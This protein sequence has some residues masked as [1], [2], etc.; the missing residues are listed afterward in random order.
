MTDEEVRLQS[1]KLEVWGVAT[2]PGL[3]GGLNPELLGLYWVGGV[4]TEVR[5]EEGEGEETE[6]GV[7]TGER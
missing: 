1:W 7:V 4:G 5:E 2:G 6:G 3:K